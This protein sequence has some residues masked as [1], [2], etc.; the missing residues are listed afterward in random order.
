MSVIS[1]EEKGD[2]ERGRNPIAPL[3]RLA[4]TSGKELR[5]L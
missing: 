4:G 1:M 5:I 3:S 2:G